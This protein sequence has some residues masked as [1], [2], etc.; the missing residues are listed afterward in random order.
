MAYY[1]NTSHMDKKDSFLKCGFMGPIPLMA[2]GQALFLARHLLSAPHQRPVWHKP[3]AAEDPLVYRVASSP[4][5]L[6]ILRD[7]IGDDIVL[8][9][10]S[11]ISKQPGEIHPWH[12]D[13]ESCGPAGG[14]VSVWIGLLNTHKENSLLFVRGSHTYGAVLQELSAR[15]QVSRN[16]MT[17]DIVLRLANSQ[18]PGAEIV[19][20]EV[21]DGEAMIFDGRIWHGSHN[22]M[23]GTPR[24]S[25][26]LQYAR[27]NIA[28][29]VPDFSN[30]EWPFRFRED[31]RHSVVAVTGHTDRAANELVPPPSMRLDQPIVPSA[32]LIAPNL[33]CKDGVS[34]ASTPCFLGRTDNADYLECHYSVL[35]PGACPHPPHTHTE[36]EILVVM[37]G[38][39][40]L[41][42]P[43][44]IHD[45]NPNIFPAPTGTAIYYPAYQRHTIRNTSSEPVCYAMIKWKSSTIKAAE[46]LKPQLVQSTWIQNNALPGTRSQTLLFEGPTRSQTLLFEGP[47]RFLEKLHAHVTGF[48]PGEGYAAH[49]DSHDVVIFFIRGQFSILGKSISA[50]AVVFLPARCLH[51]MQATGTEMANYIV[52]ELHKNR[53]PECQ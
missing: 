53:G 20:P 52:W 27:A 40:E 4:E 17:D 3:L 31:L 51:N 11:I 14:F 49:R 39:A 41:I 30:L 33:R 37:R 47:T 46:Q 34:F 43:T 38:S 18:R 10:G 48:Q 42:V 7:L 36:E 45:G 32:H 35:M 13:I 26:L 21:N 25:L 15:N 6:R 19:Q 9:G 1:D 8:W 23:S 12:C 24:V 16:E 5:L 2:K 28:V 44:S 29:K 50:P 22:P